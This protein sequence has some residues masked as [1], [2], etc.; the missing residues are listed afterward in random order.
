MPAMTRIWIGFAVVISYGSIYPLDFHPRYLDANTIQAFL[1]SCCQEFNRGDILGNVVLFLPYGFLG[2]VSAKEGA[3][4]SRQIW[5]V[6]VT[7]GALALALQVAQFYLPSRNENLQDVA[8][9]IIGTVG[10]V[11]AGVYSRK[12][13][14]ASA[15]GQRHQIALV[16]CLLVG[17]WLI[18]RLIPFVPSV[19]FQ[20]IKDSLK[21]LLLDPTISAVSV[22]HDAVAWLVI[23]SLMLGLRQG[24]KLDKYLPHLIVAVFGLE[25]LIVHNSL[26]ASNVTGAVMALVLWWGGLRRVAWQASGLTVLL[27]AMLIAAGLAPFTLAASSQPSGWLP[28]HGLLGRSM[29]V[30]VQSICEK[31]FLYGSLIYVLWQTR[32]NQVIGVFVGVAVVA[33]IEFAQIYVANHTPEITDPLLMVL[34]A[35]TMIS[36]GN[37]RNYAAVPGIA[38]GMGTAQDS[39]QDTD[40][41]SDLSMAGESVSDSVEISVNLRRSH[42]AFLDQVS[43]KMETDVSSVCQMIIDLA[44]EEISEPA[45]PDAPTRRTDRS[46]KRRGFWTAQETIFMR[47]SRTT[48][49]RVTGSER[50][51]RWSVF[52]TRR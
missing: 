41:V 45:S 24:V 6:C 34:A 36:L 46:H 51:S 49:Q 12:Y 52:N 10:G 39:G 5:L 13:I 4:R 37:Q 40:S 33:C 35:L 3:A 2:M 22:A 47:T 16:P 9:N 14:L 1:E 44:F 30:N 28:F 20:A 29:Y 26:S 15:A 18:Y 19:D 43:E 7:G 17:S 31:V 23:A 8:W 48:I 42:V 27:C 50:K 38:Q 11:V 21:P 32:L 25:I